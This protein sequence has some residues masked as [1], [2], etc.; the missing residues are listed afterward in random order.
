MKLSKNIPYFNLA[1]ALLAT[2]ELDAMTNAEWSLL[3]PFLNDES[4]KALFIWMHVPLFYY[5]FKLNSSQTPDTVLKFR[6][7]A[8][9]FMIVHSVAHLVFSLFHPGYT[10]APPV[11]T[12]T[13]HGA[14]LLSL[15]YLVQ[16]RKNQH[17]DPS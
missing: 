12:V 11:E 7:Y 16:Q 5:M 9:L 1:L 6:F 8:G 17:P 10:F 3:F 14:G 15:L 4:A 2:H 13:V